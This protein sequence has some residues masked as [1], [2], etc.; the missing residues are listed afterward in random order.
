MSIRNGISLEIKQTNKKPQETR[1]RLLESIGKNFSN[2]FLVIISA[3]QTKERL[4]QS[5][6]GQE[7]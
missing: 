2:Y 6:L 3:K 5:T 4:N 1:A 7:P